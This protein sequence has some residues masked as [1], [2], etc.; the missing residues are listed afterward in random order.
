M[1]FVF[2][3]VDYMK[4]GFMLST[5]YCL[6]A[7]CFFV[8]RYPRRP[9]TADSIAYQ[10]PMVATNRIHSAVISACEKVLDKQQDTMLLNLM[11]H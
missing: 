1:I 8:L 7:M 5:K 6:V 3:F 4:V 11:Q 9:Q 10:T 2:Q